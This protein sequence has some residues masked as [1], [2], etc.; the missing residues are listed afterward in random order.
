MEEQKNHI[1]EAKRI[2]AEIVL[3]RI[4]ESASDCACSSFQKSHNF[5]S[6]TSFLICEDFRAAWKK[7]KRHYSILS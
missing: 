5:S 2:A 1:T 6:K 4:S 3:P 7:E